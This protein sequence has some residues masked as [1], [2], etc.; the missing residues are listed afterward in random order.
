MLRR[1]Y[2]LRRRRTPCGFTPLEL[3]GWQAVDGEG[4]PPKPRAKAGVPKSPLFFNG[5]GGRRPSF[6]SLAKIEGMARRWARHAVL[7]TPSCEGVAPLGAPSRRR[8]GAGPRFLTVRFALPPALS[9][10]APF[11][12]PCLRASGKPNGPPSASSSQGVVVLPGGA[13]AP[14]GRRRSVRLL[15]AGAASPMSGL[16]DIGPVKAIPPSRRLMR[17][18]SLDRTRPS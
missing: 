7:V 9:T 15:P 10:L 6:P 14:P 18:P 5:V 8:Y 4:C 12:R 16:P 3:P 1:P 13:P 17:A 11:G 2:S